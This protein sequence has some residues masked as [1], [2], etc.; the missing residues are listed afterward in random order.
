MDHGQEEHFSEGA[1]FMVPPGHDAW[2][3]GDEAAVFVEFSR[4]SDGFGK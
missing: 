4:G 3:A 1:V 2:C